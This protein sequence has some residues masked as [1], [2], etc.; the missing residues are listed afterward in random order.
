MNSEA[1]ADGRD[2]EL[3]NMPEATSCYLRI[4]I[5]KFVGNCEG[6]HV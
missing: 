6:E 5:E 1:K 2:A 3:R 4:R